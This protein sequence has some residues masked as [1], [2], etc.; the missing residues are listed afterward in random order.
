MSRV[1]PLV[2]EQSVF[3]I[4]QVKLLCRGH[5]CFDRLNLI[6]TDAHDQPVLLKGAPKPMPGLH[7]FR[8]R[9]GILPGAKTGVEA[10]FSTS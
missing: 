8:K 9:S 6:T 3:A 7:F 4:Q 5:R 2:D 1:L 10:R